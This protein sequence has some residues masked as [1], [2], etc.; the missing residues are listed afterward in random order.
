[1]TNHYVRQGATGS[2]T[3]TDWTN[4]WTQLPST[5]IRG[6]T[7]YIADGTYPGYVFDD[8]ISGSL[9]ITIKKATIIDH[10]TDVGWQN[11]DGDSQA[12]F[13]GTIIFFTNDYIIDGN[14]TH[15]IPS[16][17][18]NDYGFKISSDSSTNNFGIVQ[19][20]GGC[21]IT[22]KYIHIYNTTNGSI[23]N[24]T[25]CLRFT[26]NSKYIKIQNCYLENSGKD[27]I[28]ISSSKWAITQW[29]NTLSLTLTC[30]TSPAWHWK[31]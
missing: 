26:N 24:C 21:N 17:N 9:Y 22:L 4:A 3:G 29:P 16:D 12:I 2:N 30:S 19:F 13:N 14:G 23:N 1:M 28:Q 8:S 15:L 20:S 18:T 27:G 25:V 6:D 31:R 10:G 5:L 7:Y 11:I